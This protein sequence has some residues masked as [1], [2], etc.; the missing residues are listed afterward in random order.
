MR[1]LIAVNIGRDP[2]EPHHSAAAAAELL[3][4]MEW[5]D[6]Y[7]VERS[8]DDEVVVLFDADLPDVTRVMTAAWYLVNA[9]ALEGVELVVSGANPN[10]MLRAIFGSIP[11]PAPTAWPET[12]ADLQGYP[13]DT[14]MMC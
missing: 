14:L 1:T 4:M 12:E 7:A 9:K 13:E 3:D 2:V 10:G 5:I 11:A 6:D 8:A